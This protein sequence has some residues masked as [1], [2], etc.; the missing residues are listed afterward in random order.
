MKELYNKYKIEKSNGNPIDEGSEY[1]VLRLDKGGDKKHV[2]ACR[3][4][5]ITYASEIKDYLPELSN[6]L[7]EKYASGKNQ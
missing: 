1:F 2:D 6:D 7:Y 3:K 5:I 4:A